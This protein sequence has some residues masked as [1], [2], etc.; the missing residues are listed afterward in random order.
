MRCRSIRSKK[1]LA[2]EVNKM[3]RVVCAVARNADLIC[4]ANRAHMPEGPLAGDL[5]VIGPGR[6]SANL[7]IT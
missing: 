4:S 3:G 5:Q 1:T 7:G 6:L 2:V